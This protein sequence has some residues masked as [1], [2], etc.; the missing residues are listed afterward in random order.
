VIDTET[1]PQT[2]RTP[3]AR[4]DWRRIDERCA[5]LGAHTHDERAERL[6]VG[7]ASLFRWRAGTQDI[8]LRR[9]AEMAAA[10]G[11][12]LREILLIAPP[13]SPPPSPPPPQ[14]DRPPGPSTPPPPPGPR[15]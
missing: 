9:A 10:V 14:P 8:G 2:D 5:E 12:H 4:L 6:G 11:L 1:L 7:R 3:F 13:G 15:P